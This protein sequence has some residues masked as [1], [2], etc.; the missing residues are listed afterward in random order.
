MQVEIVNFHTHF[1]FNAHSE[2]NTVTSF[3]KVF[4]VRS[5]GHQFIPSDSVY[6]V[7]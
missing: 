3:A 5:N 4:G 7:W 2:G 6:T 1:L